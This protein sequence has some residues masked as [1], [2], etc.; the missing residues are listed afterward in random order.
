MDYADIENLNI[1]GIYV[2]ADLSSSEYGLL[3]VFT[4]E[5]VC[6]IQILC[7]YDKVRYRRSTIDD[8]T[9]FNVSWKEL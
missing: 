8:T 1:P 6:S 9:C 5:D 7:T 4:A 2:F 3:I